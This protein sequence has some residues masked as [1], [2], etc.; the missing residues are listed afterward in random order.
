[1]YSFFIRCKSDEE[2]ILMRKGYKK[3]KVASYQI[4]ATF[5]CFIIFMMA[6]LAWSHRESNSDQRFRKP[7][8]YPLNYGT[9]P[10]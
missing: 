6:I 2:R 5:Y 4:G 7:P 10:W 8:F 3:I 9:F 1:M